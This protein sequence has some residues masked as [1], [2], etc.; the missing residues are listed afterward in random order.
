MLVQ[1]DREMKTFNNNECL[2]FQIIF[3]FQ[4]FILYFLIKY[5]YTQKFSSLIFC[6]EIKILR[7][8]MT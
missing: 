8:K 1:L 6:L 2:F 5:K 3:S 4:L 7:V